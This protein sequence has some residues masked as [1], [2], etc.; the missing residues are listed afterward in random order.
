[1]RVK[2]SVGDRLVF[3]LVGGVVGW[4]TGVML[5]GAF[6]VVSLLPVPLGMGLGWGLSRHRR[7]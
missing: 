3:T 4:F 6:G 1:M 2:R 7:Q 5:L